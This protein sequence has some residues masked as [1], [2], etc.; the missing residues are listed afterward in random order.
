MKLGKNIKLLQ[1]ETKIL[2]CDWSEKKNISEN[3][4]FFVKLG[5]NI[6]LLQSET[7]ILECDWSENYRIQEN[8]DFL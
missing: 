7:K 8:A 3:A 2:E 5:N 4:D 6:K 1:S